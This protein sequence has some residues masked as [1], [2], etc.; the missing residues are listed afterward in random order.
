MDFSDPPSGPD[1]ALGVYAHLPFCAAR[2]SYCDFAT[3]VGRT[4]A[5]DAYLRAMEREI[6]AFEPAA[7]R[8]ADT[9]YLGGGTPSSLPG[10]YLA[11]VIQAVRGRLP[12]APDAEV[13]AEGNPES[14]TDA[15]Y[16]EWLEA[17]VNRVSVGVQS[18]DDDVLRRVGRL[19]GAAEAEAAVRRA[20]AAGFDNVSVD[21]ILGLPGERI[22]RWGE[23]LDRIAALVPDHVSVYL[24]ETDKNAPLARAI[25]SGRVG[26]LDDDALAD[27]YRSTVEVLAGHG[28]DLYEISNFARPGRESRHNLKYWT[29]L[30]YAAFGLGAHAYDGRR[31]RANTTDFDRYLEAGASGEDPV[32][33]VDEWDPLRRAEESL[34]LGLRLA[35]GVDVARVEARYGVELRRS[36]R[37][38]WDRAAAAALVA[39]EGTRVRLTA[40]G[41]IL[42]NELFSELLEGG[43]ERGRRS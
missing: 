30:P 34:I 28:L 22:D 38:G 14:L 7:A 41:R 19:H 9:L 11:R 10:A 33:S 26:A 16:A 24:L 17:G 13:T 35:T 6:F 2:C 5:Q 40:R 31:R 27:A 29:D 39:W 8:R 20:R 32:E 18:L 3:V 4:A 43:T 1:A 23:T 42:A 37:D 15:R 36:R 21:L 25:R 12:L